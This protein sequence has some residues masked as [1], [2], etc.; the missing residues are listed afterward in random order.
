MEEARLPVY[1]V[2][3]AVDVPQNGDDAR[4]FE[5]GIRKVL[6][7]TRPRVRVTINDCPFIIIE[8]ETEDELR[9]YVREL[10]YLTTHGSDKGG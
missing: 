4:R 7:K 8:A 5:D 10:E 6:N 1:V 3:M 9:D 2:Q